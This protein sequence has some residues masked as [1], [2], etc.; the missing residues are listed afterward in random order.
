MTRA[1]LQAA[2][3]TVLAGIAVGAHRYV[4]RRRAP[5]ADALEKVAGTAM[6]AVAAIADA[7]AGLV[8]AAFAFA[9]VP[10]AGASPV[11]AGEIDATLDTVAAFAV[12]VAVVQVVTHLVL[13]RVAHHLEPWP[14]RPARSAE[15]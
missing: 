6:R 11:R 5:L 1:L 3:I 12:L 9:A 15:A 7:V 13:Y 4:V 10:A 2:E 14:P 8:Y